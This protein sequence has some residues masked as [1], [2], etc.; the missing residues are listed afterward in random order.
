MVA[1]IK[2]LK[3]GSD[4]KQNRY[5]ASGVTTALIKKQLVRTGCTEVALHTQKGHGS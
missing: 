5:V 3:G 1:K 2:T 4:S